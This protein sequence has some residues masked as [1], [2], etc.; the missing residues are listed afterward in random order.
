[1]EEV[2]SDSFLPYL[3]QAGKVAGHKVKVKVDW[4]SF[5]AEHSDESRTTVYRLLAGKDLKPGLG[6]LIDI[7][8]RC[9]YLCDDVHNLCGNATMTSIQDL[10]LPLK[11]IV[12]KQS[13]SSTAAHHIMVCLSD[14]SIPWPVSC[15]GGRLSI[16]SYAFPLYSII[17]ACHSVCVNISGGLYE[18]KSEVENRSQSECT[19]EQKRL[20]RKAHP[21][22]EVYI[23]WTSFGCVGDT[24]AL[25]TLGR[26]GMR[27]EMHRLAAGLKNLLWYKVE[28]K[29]LTLRNVALAS[30]T[31]LSIENDSIILA[32]HASHS[33]I[34]WMIR[35][36]DI[37]TQF[38]E[39][40]V[41]HILEMGIEAEP[42]FRD[43][44]VCLQISGLKL[45]LSMERMK[46]LEYFARHASRQMVSPLSLLKTCVSHFMNIEGTLTHEIEQA[47]ILCPGVW[48]VEGIQSD[49]KITSGM[50][51]WVTT[52]ELG[53]GISHNTFLVRFRETAKR[54][55]MFSIMSKRNAQALK[56]PE[57]GGVWYYQ[58]FDMKSDL[59]TIQR[60]QL[61]SFENKL[62]HIT[63]PFT[64]QT[65]LLNIPSQ[66]KMGSPNIGYGN[67]DEKTLLL[68]FEPWPAHLIM[69]RHLK[70]ST[71]RMYVDSEA[72]HDCWK[73]GLEMGIN[74]VIDTEDLRRYG[75]YVVEQI[76]VGVAR[77]L[78]LFTQQND[79]LTQR[80]FRKSL[81]SQGV[82]LVGCADV[83]KDER[84]PWIAEGTS[85][86]DMYFSISPLSENDI[87]VSC[88]RGLEVLKENVEK[89]D[90]NKVDL[91]TRFPKVLTL[92]FGYKFVQTSCRR[93]SHMLHDLCDRRGALVTV[94]FLEPTPE[95][96]F[97]PKSKK[98]FE[99]ITEVFKLANTVYELKEM[100][101]KGL[102]KVQ[103]EETYNDESS[104]V[105]YDNEVLTVL[106]A[107]KG[108]PVA[109]QDII[110]ALFTR[111]G[112]TENSL[113]TDADGFSQT[114]FDDSLWKHKRSNLHG[115][116]FSSDGEVGKLQQ[117]SHE[118]MVLIR[119]DNPIFFLYPHHEDACL[120]SPAFPQDNPLE[121]G[122]C[123]EHVDF[124]GFTFEV[125]YTPQFGTKEMKAKWYTMN[126]ESATESLFSFKMV[127]PR[128]KVFIRARCRQCKAFIELYTK[129]G[130]ANS[131]EHLE[132]VFAPGGDM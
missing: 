91:Y 92:A 33:N 51:C 19:I 22:L 87:F 11:E 21:E 126:Y 125:T 104:V 68:P 42:D 113:N 121:H 54:K 7:L 127:H 38:Q 1:M 97:L 109:A 53:N 84:T 90:L 128:P 28:P 31:S 80:L 72:L 40:E 52:A 99:T 26:N 18:L 73:K 27:L 71:D 65:L 48:P 124:S 96:T 117:R 132:V 43:D 57:V 70:Q 66:I 83:M 29:Q 58:P 25:S 103:F 5:N 64:I 115:R 107:N 100:F 39:I 77:S 114:D 120:I 15:K 79:S 123:V 17:R 44:E 81:S 63:D 12:V 110:K 106:G 56:Q 35:C 67:K 105:K 59:K 23:D 24:D 45:C 75:A 47:L 37:Y 41:R 60:L 46:W 8:Q 55:D 36:L 49:L 118:Q 62:Y 130:K 111:F 34:G 30:E 101:T 122:K 93:L 14:Q 131:G 13:S 3:S 74:V 88:E 78:E 86:D 94:S 119:K 85:Y 20:S 61:I 69:Y 129:Y 112:V 95:E 2:T 9:K 89:V 32:M 76:A 16:T 98:V 116:R 102:R 6:G 50:W 108:I 10:L 4:P 82:L